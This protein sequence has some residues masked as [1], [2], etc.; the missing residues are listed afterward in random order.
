[1]D[2]AKQLLSH[3]NGRVQAGDV[4]GGM[5]AL[6]KIK[7]DILKIPPS[8]E[9]VTLAANALELGVLLTVASGDLDVF[10]RNMA[11]LKP[12]YSRGARSD[13][14]CHVLGLNL[15]FLLVENRLSEFHSELELL[16]ETEAT[17]KFI[18]FPIQLERQLMVGS[19]DEV[20]SAHSRIPDPS[21][22]FFM[23]NLL[24]TVRDSIADCLEVSYKE[25]KIEDAMKMMKFDSSQHLIE[26]IDECRDDWI[27]EGTSICFQPPAVG[28]K[29]SDIP[30]MKLI[31][32][33]LTYA[34]E[35]ER[36]I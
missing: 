5:K 1:M 29:A 15:M 4:E 34:T 32:Q 22:G 9:Q 12:T 6:S 23:D 35:M 28:S 11:Q 3:M 19:Y 33:S 30:S 36:I 2:S 31:S 13:R 21:Y 20:L 7:I 10:A 24:Q 27:V 18:S 25:M 14:K 8:A 26:Y 16:T 17:N